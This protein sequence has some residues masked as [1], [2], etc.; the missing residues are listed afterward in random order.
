[1]RGRVPHIRKIVVRSLAVERNRGVKRE[2]AARGTA[3]RRLPCGAPEGGPF[4]PERNEVLNKKS[5]KKSGQKRS[6]SCSLKK[7]AAERLSFL[8][9]FS[10]LLQKQKMQ[11]RCLRVSRRFPAQEIS[12]ERERMPCVYHFPSTTPA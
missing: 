1:M 3:R 11:K 4:A 9:R 10:S 12:C 5:T 6:R 7:Y 2:Q 8:I